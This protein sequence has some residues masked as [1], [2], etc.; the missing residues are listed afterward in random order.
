M[1]GWL[2]DLRLAF[3]TLA[4]SKGFTLISVLTLGLGIGLNTAIFSGVYGFLWMPFPYPQAE[5]LVALSQTNPAQGFQD[6]NIS[7]LDGED[8]R[9]ARSLESLALYAFQSPALTGAGEPVNVATVSATP[10]LFRVLRAEPVLGR[11]FGPAEQGP[12]EHRVAILSDGLWQ[13]RFRSDPAVVGRDIRLDDKNYTVIGVLPPKFTFLYEDADVFLPLE[14][15]PELRGNRGYRWLAA[16]GRLSPGASVAQAQAEV[17]AISARMER[18]A[19]E[20]NQGW[21]GKVSTLAD[22]VIPRDARTASH[23]VLVAVGFVLLIAC[24]N[25]ANLLLA[26]GALRSRE[27]AVRTSLGAGRLALVRLLLAESMVLALVGSCLGVVFAY[28][29]IPLLKAVVP[30][31]TPRVD[32][33]QLNVPSLV[34]M[35]GLCLATGLAS[36]IAPAWLLSRSEPAA[37]LHSAGRGS[38]S[39]RQRAINVLV[40]AEVA[41]TLVLLA[42]S[43]VLIRSLELQVSVSP[44]FD[45]RNLLIARVS[46]PRY[47][48]TTSTQIADF[49]RQVVTMLGTDAQVKSAV[50]A[51]SLPLG[52]WSSFAAIS[53]EGRAITDPRERNIVARTIATPGYFRTFGIPLVIGRDFDDRDRPEAPA[54]AIVNET[55]AAR[56]WGDPA[57]ALGRRFKTGNAPAAAWLTVA[58]VAKDVRRRSQA[59]PARAEFFV[60]HAQSPSRGMTVIARTTTDPARLAA[61]MR[62][63][64]WGVDRDQPLR[65]VESVE[66]LME[67]RA[68]SS[69]ALV[70]I[71]GFLSLVALLLAAIGIYGVMAYTTGQRTREIGVRMALGAQRADIFGLVIRSGIGPMAAG[72]VI[73]LACAYG[74]TPLLESLLVGLPPHDWPTFLGVSLILAVVG[75]F[76][77]ALPAQRATRVDPIT[78]LRVE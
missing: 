76:A 77:C 41:L 74:V 55:M 66:D 71:L 37:V 44:G 78:T 69:G 26:R 34:Y 38:T 40:V 2:A 36:G 1:R 35:L 15:T 6:T 18:E 60:P 51:D 62:A 72:V 43:G 22:A 4:K 57:G 48:Y 17:R 12:G 9:G 27:L 25:I 58:A 45:P 5:N 49:F 29:G 68:A 53:V 47:R 11:G 42:A 19:P 20:T 67:R 33:M 3:R 46:L 59:L 56:Y 61:A 8:W 30:P 63:V 75:L 50:A 23:T 31:D 54:V 65:Q 52:G 7:Y 32:L 10:E 64:V 24:A 73:G 70:R 16:I 21:S 28:W 14:L 39:G 13:R